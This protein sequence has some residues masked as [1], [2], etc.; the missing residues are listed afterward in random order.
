MP[1]TIDLARRTQR[2]P[3]LAFFGVSA[4]F[5][6]LG[7]AFAVLLFTQVGTLGVA[8]LRNLV[9]AA[10]FAAWRRPWRHWATLPWRQRRLVLALGG[11]LGV[12][13]V[14]FYLAIAR[15]PLATVGA[16]EFLGPVMLAAAGVRTRRN[17]L[18][19]LLAASG[20]ALLFNARLASE[21]AGIA[22][23]VA[24]CGLFALYIVLGKLVVADGVDHGLDRLALA[25]LVAATVVAPL[26]L[27][28]AS[29]VVAAPVLL[30]AALGVGVSSS[31]I[32]YVT[33][34]LALARLPRATFA[35]LLCLLPAVATILGI[36]VL[37]QIP[38]WAELAGVTLVAAGIG[39]HQTKPS[40]AAIGPA[41]ARQVAGPVG[42]PGQFA[43]RVTPQREVLR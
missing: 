27:T 28:E 31:V 36:L 4:I 20:V 16:I 18:A 6:Y 32:P 33:D 42:E 41:Q 15:L 8:W 22:L 7:P 9:A 10:V 3:A 25:T 14:T 39:A 19:V 13:N 38:T 21:P 26:G 29:V 43:R 23:A 34:Q 35:L 37:T 1:M 12:M 11:T 17:G 40:E 30:L 5:H 24:N 2:V